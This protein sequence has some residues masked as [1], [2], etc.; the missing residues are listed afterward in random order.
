[1]YCSW[2]RSADVL[3]LDLDCLAL[4]GIIQEPFADHFLLESLLITLFGTFTRW[5]QL[6]MVGVISSGDQMVT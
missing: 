5:A 3:L 4:K 2:A 1:M 6:N